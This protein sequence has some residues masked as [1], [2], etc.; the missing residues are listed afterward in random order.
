MIYLSQKELNERW[1][2]L[3]FYILTISP[4]RRQ[5]FPVFYRVEPKEAFIT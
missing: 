3:S 5:L 4:Q 1:S 2:N